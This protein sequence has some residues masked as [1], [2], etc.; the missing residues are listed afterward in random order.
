MPLFILFKF[1]G[2]L[3]INHTIILRLLVTHQTLEFYCPTNLLEIF[4]QFIFENL[5]QTTYDD[6]QMT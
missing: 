4:P 3:H 5:F 6:E 1:L 2:K